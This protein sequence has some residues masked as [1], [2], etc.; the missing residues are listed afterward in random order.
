[1]PYFSGFS[2][3][4]EKEL[5]GV[6]FEDNDFTI[7]GFSYG[8]QKALEYAYNNSGRI[9]KLILLSPA[10]FQNQTNGFLRAQLRYFKKDKNAYMQT[11]IANASYPSRI[12]LQPYLHMGQEEELYSLLHYVW[13]RKKLKILQKKGIQ[14]EV[15]L[16]SEDKIIDTKEVLEFFKDIAMIYVVKN[17]GHCLV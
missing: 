1:M 17:A 6:Y 5:F 7:V 12:D 14:I 10:F 3:A 2:L 11:F 13:D 4:K 16:G 15:F 9:D 8:A